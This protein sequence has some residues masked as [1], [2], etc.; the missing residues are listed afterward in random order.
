MKKNHVTN[1]ML[2]DLDKQVVNDVE[3]GRMT[4]PLSTLWLNTL[5]REYTRRKKAGLI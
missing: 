2:L 5:T 3:I 4:Q 1:E